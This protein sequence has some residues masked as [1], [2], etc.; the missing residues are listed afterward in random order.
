MLQ[1]GLPEQHVVFLKE[2]GTRHKGGNFWQYFVKSE[3]LR[4]CSLFRKPVEA[5]PGVP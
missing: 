1:C 3:Y 2:A 5:D 4:L